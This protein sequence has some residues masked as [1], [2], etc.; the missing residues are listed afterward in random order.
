MTANTRKSIA[1][2]NALSS[3]ADI[4]FTL[5]QRF[6]TAGTPNIRKLREASAR[7]RGRKEFLMRICIGAFLA[8]AWFPLCAAAQSPAE[9]LVGKVKSG[10]T[11]YLL[12]SASREISGVFGKVSDSTMT[13]MVNG[14]LRDVSLSDV[15]EISRRGGDPLWNG[16][17]IGALIGGVGAGVSSQNVSLGISGAI[18]YGGIGAVIDKL[19]AGRVVV[20]RTPG[21]KSVAIAPVVGKGRRGVRVAVRF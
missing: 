10:D 5:F 13:L 11:V 21:A 7:S 1:Y 17:F 6:F 15:R 8:A 19:V 4:R 18:L 16:V 2:H 3:P 20:Y 14:E 12:D 9:S